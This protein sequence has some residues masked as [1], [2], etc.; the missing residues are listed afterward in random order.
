MDSHNADKLPELKTKFLQLFERGKTVSP[1]V[2]IG[3]KQFLL[4]IKKSETL[5][6]GSK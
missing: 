3:I 4:W 5:G 6:G 1:I 2:I